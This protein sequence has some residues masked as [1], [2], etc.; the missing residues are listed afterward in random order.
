MPAA[1]SAAVRVTPVLPLP[2]GSSA[3]TAAA[4]CRATV[5]QRGGR[6]LLGRVGGQCSHA[7]IRRSALS[8]HCLVAKWWAVVRSANGRVTIVK[9]RPERNQA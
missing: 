1:A 7:S 3:P 5:A 6:R 8:G 4:T 2:L 9:M